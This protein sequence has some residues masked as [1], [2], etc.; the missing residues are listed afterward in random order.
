M[1][2]IDNSY[3]GKKKQ[4]CVEGKIGFLKNLALEPLRTLF[5]PL[6]SI[7]GNTLLFKLH[8]AP[9]AIYTTIARY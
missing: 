8:N 6:R 9:I 4:C 5:W 1:T 3:L 7:F 2:M